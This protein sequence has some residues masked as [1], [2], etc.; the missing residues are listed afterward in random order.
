[1]PASR[2]SIR[3]G[4]V[5]LA[6][7]PRFT[8]SGLSE[9][10]WHVN[11]RVSSV[12][13]RI[14]QITKPTTLRRLSTSFHHQVSDMK[15]RLYKVLIRFP[16]LMFIS[17]VHALTAF[18]L[19]LIGTLF[20]IAPPNDTVFLLPW[21]LRTISP[22][23]YFAF[24]ALHAIA[25][26]NHKSPVIRTFVSLRDNVVSRVAPLMPATKKTMRHRVA[27]LNDLFVL[28]GHVCNVIS[29]SYQGKRMADRTTN[30][31]LTFGFTMG[32]AVYA[33]LSPWLLFHSNNFLRRTSLLAMGCCFSFLLSTVLSTLVFLPNMLAFF[34]DHMRSSAN[35]FEWQTNMI[36]FNRYVVVSSFGDLV[37]KLLPHATS[38]MTLE[39]LA[40]S[41]DQAPVI[42]PPKLRPIQ[43]KWAPP[44]RLQHRAAFGMVF[45]VKRYPRLMEFDFTKKYAFKV[46]LALSIIWGFTVA[47]VAIQSTWFREPC[48]SECVLEVSSWFTTTCDCVFYRLN[49]ALEENTTST[50]ENMIPPSI[51]SSLFF[52][53]IVR[54]PIPLGPSGT[55]LARFPELF[56]LAIEL[57]QMH[58]WHITPEEIPQ[59]LMQLEIRHSALEKV[60]LV[61][62]NLSL[63]PNLIH[64]SIIGSTISDIPLFFWQTWAPQLANLVISQAN[65]S[66]ITMFGPNESISWPN[67]MELDLS[68][69][70]IHD[71]PIAPLIN[72]STLAKLSLA[73]NSI[74]YLPTL[75]IQIR[76]SLSIN[77]NFNPINFQATDIQ[78]SS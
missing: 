20:L 23:F 63:L 66:A 34:L 2:S 75:L 52:L 26:Y 53:N 49:C 8:S 72:S 41:L 71:I 56:G 18:H 65:L 46:Y 30:A 6:G 14:V 37:V 38:Y 27:F 55:L 39:L 32:V 19:T 73:N 22:G 33:M 1:M 28:G 60:P 42:P 70:Q 47:C 57:S 35:Y 76:S 21:N 50:I 59:S 11:E 67:L 74:S 61:L 45:V 36:L 5:V 9:L 43:A 17:T 7:P 51:G 31:G 10:N 29:F 12:V 64:I 78:I 58:N 3:R 44:Q 25:I 54:C 48:P 68:F 16:V 15:T 4:S 40:H 62:S 77:L 13:D 69:N 24:A